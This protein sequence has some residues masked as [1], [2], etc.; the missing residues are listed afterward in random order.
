M[1]ERLGAVDTIFADNDLALEIAAGSVDAHFVHCSFD[2]NAVMMKSTREVFFTDCHIETNGTV[3]TG[4]VGHV[5]HTAD[6]AM[7]VFTNCTFVLTAILSEVFEPYNTG[8]LSDIYGRSDTFSFDR[9]KWTVTWG[10]FVS[11]FTGFPHKRL[12]NEISGN[13]NIRRGIFAGIKVTGNPGPIFGASMVAGRNM[14][15]VAIPGAVQ[16]VSGGTAST[17]TSTLDNLAG[18]PLSSL[19]V[20]VG[21]TQA[22]TNTQNVKVQIPVGPNDY[23]KRLFVAQKADITVV[24]ADSQRTV[25]AR[26]FTRNDVELNTFESWAGFTTLATGTTRGID[27]FPSGGWAYS[28]IPFGAAYISIEVQITKIRFGDSFKLYAPQV[29]IV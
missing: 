14:A 27:L 18:G 15:G 9:T 12:V 23:G 7:T 25:Y 11:R 10:T 17:V 29:N 21:A 5:Q 6:S 28:T 3:W 8:T 2:Y 4:A 16:T 19:T 1:G 22:G 13:R 24:G 26:S 20:T